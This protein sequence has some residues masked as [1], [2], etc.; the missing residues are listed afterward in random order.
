MNEINPLQ[1]NNY[2]KEPIT[3]PRIYDNGL[4]FGVHGRTS[5]NDN[6]DVEFM[7]ARDALYNPS[8]YGETE[9]SLL[10]KISEAAERS[11]QNVKNGFG[12]TVGVIVNDGSSYV[13]PLSG[14]EVINVTKEPL[15]L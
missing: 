6:Y 15:D 11:A 7:G 14:V 4:R 5:S 10:A 2:L 9:Q 12:K 3:K 8:N 1:D 13:T